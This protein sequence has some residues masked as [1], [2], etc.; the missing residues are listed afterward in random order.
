MYKK[1]FTSSKELGLSRLKTR[2][3]P[4]ACLGRAPMVIMSSVII[5]VTMIKTTYLLTYRGH[6]IY[7]FDGKTI[8]YLRE[9][10]A[11]AGKSA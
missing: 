1:D 4:S 10:S 7:H 11:M 6:M 3:S 5:T 2:T 9:S 8:Y